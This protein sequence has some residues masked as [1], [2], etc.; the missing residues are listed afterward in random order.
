MEQQ[1]K[2]QEEKLKRIQRK[3]KNILHYLLIY[4]ICLLAA[5]I[6]WLLVRYSMREERADDCGAQASVVTSTVMDAT[7]TEGVLYV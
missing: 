4:L 6:T 2:M 7:D 5:C 1:N 3:K